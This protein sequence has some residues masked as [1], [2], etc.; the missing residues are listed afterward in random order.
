L[1]PQTAKPGVTRSG[2]LVYGSRRG[3]HAGKREQ[4]DSFEGVRAQYGKGAKMSVRLQIEDMPDYR[5]VRVTGAIREACEQFELI[6]EHCERA[7][8]SKLLLDFTDT[9]GEFFLADRYFL[10]DQSGTF[11]FHKLIKVA[12]VVRPEQ[13][14][15]QKFGEIVARNRWVN[16]RVF[17]NVEDAKEWLLK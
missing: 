10:G 2:R 7:N 13:L 14:D 3:L 11:M 4:Y 9:H 1:P 12:A 5:A 6:A 15:S 17:T 16:A 8:K